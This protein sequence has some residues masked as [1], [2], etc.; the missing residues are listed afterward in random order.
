MKKKYHILCLAL[1]LL[2]PISANAQFGKLKNAIKKT[3]GGA[4]TVTTV[5]GKTKSL[6]KE[7]SATAKANDPKATDETIPEG[8]TK[9]IKEL[10][11]AYEALPAEYFHQ[12]YYEYA[13]FYFMDTPE[14]QAYHEKAYNRFCQYRSQGSIEVKSSDFEY[15]K[16]NSGRMI[17]ICVPTAYALAARFIADPNSLAGTAAYVDLWIWT[18]AQRSGVLYRKEVKDKSGDVIAYA[19]A[20]GDDANKI[21]N[22][23]EAMKVEPHGNLLLQVFDKNY[24]AFNNEKSGLNKLIYYRRMEQAYEAIVRNHHSDGIT[25]EQMENMKMRWTNTMRKIQTFW[26]AAKAEGKQMLQK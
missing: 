4:T 20:S 26:D 14:N 3:V 17:G 2:A 5:A 18:E 10:H 12:P 19:N 8:F 11:A 9:S 15:I 22:G 13:H 21:F 25:A 23:I 6:P 16:G 7:P 24:T 1:M